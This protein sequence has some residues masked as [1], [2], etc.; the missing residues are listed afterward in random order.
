MFEMSR[1]ILFFIFFQS[2]TQCFSQN[3][4]KWIFHGVSVEED[5]GCLTKAFTRHEIIWIKHDEFY[6][7]RRDS[8]NKTLKQRYNPNYFSIKMSAAEKGNSS[9]IALVERKRKC[10]GSKATIPIITVYTFFTGDTE[11]SIQRQAETEMKLYPQ[12]V[13]YK[14]LQLIKTDEAFAKL[15]NDNPTNDYSVASNEQVISYDG[16]SAR[17][18]TKK[19]GNLLV[20]A[21]F[22]N[23]NKDKIAIVVITPLGQD[24]EIQ[25][26][27]PGE[28]ITQKYS[29]NELQIQIKH[30][31]PVFKEKISIDYLKKLKDWVGSEVR[32]KDGNLIQQKKTTPSCM[33][34]R[35]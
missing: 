16:L 2:F 32:V 3:R 35:G 22:T 12:L 21:Q 18:I 20:L 8:L 14:I 30:L 1:L 26:L 23:L 27:Q 4:E 28:K 11:E 33:C 13:S 9:F 29:G 5:L 34:V 31:D 24:S 7:S 17:Y 19:E 25:V 10:T 6:K 15:E